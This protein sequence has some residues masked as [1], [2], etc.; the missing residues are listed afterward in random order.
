[1]PNEDTC[2]SEMLRWARLVIFGGIGFSGYNEK[3]NANIG[4]YR[5]T[6]DRTV[7]IKES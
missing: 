6:I 4:L 1:M 3:F 2:I 5:N 7:E